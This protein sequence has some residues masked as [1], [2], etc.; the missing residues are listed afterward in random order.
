[1]STL[2]RLF[3]SLL[4]VTLTWLSVLLLLVGA[5]TWL[6]MKFIARHAV[7]A[8]LILAVLVLASVKKAL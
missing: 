8:A 1:M 3:G 4:N 5:A 7:L 6:V 2:I